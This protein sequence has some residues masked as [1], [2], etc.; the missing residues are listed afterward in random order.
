VKITSTALGLARFALGVRRFCRTIETVP[1]ALGKVRAR[2][3]DADRAARLLAVF[4]RAIFPNPRSPYRRLLGAAGCELGDVRDLVAADGVEGALERLRAAGVY[5]KFDE[6]KGLTPA[7]RGSPRLDFRPTDFDNS[8]LRP[9]FAVTSGGT[10][11]RPTRIQIDLDYLAE[12]APHWALWFESNDW[13]A[14]P[15]VF[16]TPA[17]PSIVNRQLR[18]ASIGKPYTRWFVTGRGVSVAYDAVSVTVQA[19]A[20]WASSVPRPET[21]GPGELDRILDALREMQADGPPPCVMTTPATATRL[22]LSAVQRKRSL[23]GVAFLLAG[24]PYTD[25]RRQSVEAAG[26]RGYPFYG[27]SEAAPIGAQCPLPLASDDVHVYT[28]A[29]ALVTDPIGRDAAA[30]DPLLLTSLLASGPKVL[31]NTDIGDVGRLE[32]RR[33]ECLLGGLGYATHLSAIRSSQKLTGDGVTFVSADLWTLLEATLPRR[34]GGGPGD[35]Q[36]VEEPDAR[37]VPRYRLLVSPDVGDVDAAAVGRAFLDLLSRL[38]P[39]YGVMVNQWRHGGFLTVER[40]HPSLTAR[41]K[42]PPVRLLPS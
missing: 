30:G 22:S 37:G 2:L 36:L 42:V 17:Y 33:C 24:E 19:L 21:V 10:R 41:G 23:A 15:L 27:C 14:R 39:A 31:L 28:D 32:R 3:T 11:T 20:R 5:V 6:F 34:F 16:V 40:A 25:V 26:A 12:T 35:Y 38:R 29:F 13:M 8:V 18:C 4:E 9:S 7:V 1:S